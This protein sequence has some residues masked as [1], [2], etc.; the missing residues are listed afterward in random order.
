MRPNQKT[1]GLAITVARVDG[2]HRWGIEPILP[3]VSGGGRL[4]D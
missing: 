2:R 1:F 3:A 4:P